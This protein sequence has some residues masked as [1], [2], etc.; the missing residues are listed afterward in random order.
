MVKFRIEIQITLLALVIAAAIIT[1][2]YLGYKSIA[3]IVDS[4][5]QAARPDQALLLIN[6][7]DIGLSEIESK[8]RLYVLTNKADDTLAYRELQNSVFVNLQ[9]LSELQISDNNEKSLVD[10]I[11]SLAYKKL[12]IW[13][14]IFQL[15]QSSQGIVPSFTELYSKLEEQKI[16]TIKVEHAKK[17]VFRWIFGTKKVEIDT[18]LVPRDLK[19]E[20]IREQLQSIETE[21][22]QKGQ[23]L[24]VEESQL[25]EM[26]L[27]VDQKLNKLILQYEKNEAEKLLAKSAGA[28]RLAGLT[29]KRLA[30]FLA[31]SVILLLLILALLYNYVRK[32]RRYQKML[33][34]AK[35][36]AEGFAHAKEQFA[37][38][39]SHEIRT[40]VN[41]IFGLT[42]LLL[43]NGLSEINREKL[44]AIS[45][46]AHHLKNIVNDTLDFSKIEADKFK[47]ESVHFSPSEIFNEIAAIQ[48]PEAQSKGL[49]FRTEFKDGTPAALVGDPLR[50]KQILFNLIG[51]SLKFTESGFISLVVDSSAENGRQVW[52]NIKVE[53]S[54]IGI[55][56]EDQRVIFDEYVQ[57]EQ[58]MKVKY[59]GTG[60]GLGIVKKLVE[61]Q[62]GRISVESEKGSGTLFLIEIP[63]K[64]GESEKIQN[65]AS[66][67]LNIPDPFKN[68]FV[69]I[70]D[71][72][73]YNRFLLKSIFE[74]WG[75]RFLEAANGAEAVVISQQ[76]KFDLILM[77]MNMPKKSGV[78]AAK[79]ILAAKPGSKIIAIT[80]S[81]EKAAS[82]AT[83]AG[84]V[85]F[86]SK[87]F[88]EADLFGIIYK[89]LEVEKEIAGHVAGDPRPEINFDELKRLANF[90]QSF[91][92]EMLE[93]FIRSSESGVL[94]IENGFGSNNLLAVAD[95]AHKLS[96]PSKH[97]HA[98][99]LNSL[100]GELERLARDNKP[101]D[102]PHLIN[103]IKEEVAAVNRYIR[104][105]LKHTS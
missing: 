100:L 38:N 65:L 16:D 27:E 79:E 60:L 70:A 63:Y 76:N 89:N 56:K 13:G 92:T 86:L 62:G 43:Q 66:A 37:A 59:S 17:G 58:S 101:G 103:E 104:D 23:E 55:S 72:E 50:L 51:N 11:T 69:L 42:E 64:I 98:E 33:A 61:L 49:E 94:S 48:K 99:K 45:K 15:H 12:E 54:G 71:D 9:A 31:T 14:Q 36:E 3:Q 35:T 91:F 41:A 57:A 30:A 18:T 47:F 22:R 52:L 82:D 2:G 81:A 102:V 4:I 39:V 95:S 77:D 21:I 7:A 6:N 28:D 24:Y 20:E 93:I 34:K 75:V 46:S 40:P 97:I 44:Q 67:V 68:L 73:E 5:H 96:A 53:D 90:D 83:E 85:G 32:N 87:P 1:T 29:Y 84:M 19:K 8:T 88:S 78:D 25:I 10:S 26:N 80:A 105:Y 74:K